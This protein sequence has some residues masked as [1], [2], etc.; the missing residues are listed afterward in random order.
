MEIEK[1]Q[2][3]L[4]M[5]FKSEKIYL[6]AAEKVQVTK[7]SRFLNHQSTLRNQ[8]CNKLIEKLVSNDIE[9]VKRHIDKF[10]APISGL[11]MKRRLEIKKH[12][13]EV[14]KCLAYDNKII[15]KCKELVETPNIPIDILEILSLEMGEL[16]TNIIKGEKII[17][18]YLK[19]KHLNTIEAQTKTKVLKLTSNQH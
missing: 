2:E 17:Q 1:L 9:P 13:K 7:F 18:N 6:E 12:T 19:Q 8:L 16:L 4:K 15:G 10:T 5:T 14:K 3:L 11:E